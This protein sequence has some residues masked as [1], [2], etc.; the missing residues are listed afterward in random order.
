MRQ[1]LIG[2]VAMLIA[3]AAAAQ[4]MECVDAKGKKEYAQNCPPGTIKETTLLKGGTGPSS[5]GAAA[6]AP[7]AKSLAEQESEFRKRNIERQ[8]AEAKDAKQLADAKDAHRN[9]DNAQAQ[10]KALQDGQRITKTDPATGERA[11]LEDQDRPNEIAYAQKA[12]ANWCK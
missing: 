1:L 6:P 2:F 12:V 7:S 5:S 3:G 4:I 9:C 11:F 10:L 8:E